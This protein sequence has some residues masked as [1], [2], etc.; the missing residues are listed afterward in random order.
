[1]NDSQ[2]TEWYSQIDDLQRDIRRLE[3][4]CLQCKQAVD[5][6]DCEQSQYE[7]VYVQQRKKAT[8][9]CADFSRVR[10]ARY[11][12]PYVEQLFEKTEYQKII[13]EFEEMRESIC[14]QKI[15]AADEIEEHYRQI[16]ELEQCISEAQSL[17]RE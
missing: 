4:C 7:E 10:F 12:G 15:K 13:A 2:I 14:Y 9:L 16:T 8:D 1:M 3:E 6:I 11:Y 5:R 17:C